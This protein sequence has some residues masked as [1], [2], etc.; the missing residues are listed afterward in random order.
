MVNGVL[1]KGCKGVIPT[2]MRAEILRR[3]H[4]GHMGLNKCE[5]HVPAVWFFGQASAPTLITLSGNVHRAKRMHINNKA[6]HF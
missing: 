5:A 1:S 4:D 6:S 3:I 2:S